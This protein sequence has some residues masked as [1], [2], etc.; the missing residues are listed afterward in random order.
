M[1]QVEGRRVDEVSAI[2]R[3]GDYTV[4]HGPDGRI[5]SMTFAMPGFGDAA[6]HGAAVWN[7]IPGEGSTDERDRVRWTITEDAEGKVTVEPSILAEWPEGGG[8]R[9]F[10]AFLRGGVWDVLDDTVGA[11]FD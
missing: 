2:E 4:T 8:G 1:P 5:A 7:R 6:G 9:R 11:T 3:G 10:H